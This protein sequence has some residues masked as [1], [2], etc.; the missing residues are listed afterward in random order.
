MQLLD[1]IDRE[2]LVM[3]PKRQLTAELLA[4]IRERAGKTVW[5]KGGCKSWYLGKDGVPLVNP[6]TLTELQNDMHTVKLE[7]FEIATIREHG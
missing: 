2:G 1:K 4:A 7:D 6:L 5:A 3:A